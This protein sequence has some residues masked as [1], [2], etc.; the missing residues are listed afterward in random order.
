VENTSKGTESLDTAALRELRELT[1]DS[2][3]PEQFRELIAMFLEGLEPGIAS[4]RKALADADME[5]LAMLAH[6]FK[7]N[8]ASM[9]AMNLASMCVALEDAAAKAS[10]Q[11]APVYLKQIESEVRVVRWLMERET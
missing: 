8:C 1:Q 11:D 6:G 7:G 3:H 9:G 5:E 2:G 4:M 10:L